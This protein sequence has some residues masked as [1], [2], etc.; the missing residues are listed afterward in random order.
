MTKF[1]SPLDDG[2]RKIRGVLANWLENITLRSVQ[3]L[4]PL[5]VE[6]TTQTNT[7]TSPTVPQAKDPPS[8]SDSA[9]G[10]T[11][12]GDN[13]EPRMGPFHLIAASQGDGGDSLD[14]ISRLVNTRRDINELGGPT[15]APAISFAVCKRKPQI[16]KH[17]LQCGALPNIVDNVGQAPIWYAAHMGFADCMEILLQY[18]ADV[19]AG[20]PTALM[21]AATEGHVDIVAEL[22]KRGAN[23]EVANENLNTSLHM[24]IV[25]RHVKTARVLIAGGANVHARTIHG[26]TPL[27]LAI[28]FDVND[29]ILDLLQAGARVNEQDN[30]LRTPVM[31]AAARGN[32]ISVQL[33]L[34]AGAD[35]DI[36]SNHGASAFIAAKHEGH[37]EVYR[38]LLGRS[39]EV[40]AG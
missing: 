15:H 5:P 37:D 29:I 1:S 3:Q 16:L 12:S 40:R 27:L 13:N 28:N 8:H 20:D 26:M 18:G 10:S 17:L 11:N 36:I 34:D 25:K 7:S 38:V 2:Y 4:L 9:E 19:N 31:T 14:M 24:A 22:L 32:V 35:P 23:T 21:A 39:Q 6:P 33:L 30:E